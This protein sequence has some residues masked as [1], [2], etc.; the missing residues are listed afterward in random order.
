ML[1]KEKKKKLVVLLCGIMAL[2]MAACSN[3]ENKN[4]ENENDEVNNT[5]E[6]TNN[7]IEVSEEQEELSGDL[8]SYQ[9]SINGTIYHI[10]MWYRELEELGW[11]YAGDATTTLETNVSTQNPNRWEMGDNTIYTPFCN[12]A[13]NAAPYSE[14]EIIEIDIDKNYLTEGEWEIILPGGIQYGVSAKEDIVA[15]YG[16][17]SMESEYGVTCDLW[18]QE[19]ANHYVILGLENDIL[20]SI[21]MYNREALEGGDDS[22]SAEVPESVKNYKAPEA[23]GDDLYQMNVEIDG[24]LYALPCPLSELIAN[25]FEIDMND[26]RTDKEIASGDYG[27]AVL[28]YNGQNVVMTIHNY[29]PNATTPENCFIGGVECASDQN[30]FELVIPCNIKKGMQESELLEIL[31][32]YTYEVKEIGSENRFYSLKNPNVSADEFYSINTKDGVVVGIEVSTYV[33]PEY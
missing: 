19:G 25:G 17:P 16:E 7:S 24:H 1:K 14:S 15:A 5:Q 27:W 4:V 29:S 21:K 33:R 12:M 2:F 3:N 8:Y 10:P 6:D 18:Y 32:D 23:L 31:A 11:E 13:A 28:K 9:M 20:T 30:A 26:E 22:V